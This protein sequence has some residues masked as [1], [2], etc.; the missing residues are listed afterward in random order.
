LPSWQKSVMFQSRNSK[1]G[2]I[3]D[4]NMFYNLM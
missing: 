1:V 3:R 4:L 2:Y